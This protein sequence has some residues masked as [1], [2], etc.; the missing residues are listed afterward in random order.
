MGPRHKPRRCS[1][2][3]PTS[4]FICSATS[5]APHISVF[6]T[7]NF[8]SHCPY[9]TIPFSHPSNSR[10]SRTIPEHSLL[11]VHHWSSLYP[12][13]GT[14]TLC[15]RASPRR[16]RLCF[17]AKLS[18]SRNATTPNSTRLTR[19]QHRIRNHRPS[20]LQCHLVRWLAAAKAPAA[21]RLVVSLAILTIQTTTTTILTMVLVPHDWKINRSKPLREQSQW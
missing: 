5:R 11:I 19:T 17:R 21:V 9:P 8:A 16:S 13:T 12:S 4:P 20:H 7:N 6:H 1:R 3:S 15:R 2:S 18:V 10:A 14:S